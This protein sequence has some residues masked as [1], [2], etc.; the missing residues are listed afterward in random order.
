MLTKGFKHPTEKLYID[1]H[2]LVCMSEGHIGK[3]S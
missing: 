2:L 3:I 1:P